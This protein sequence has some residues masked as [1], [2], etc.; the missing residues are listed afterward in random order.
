MAKIIAVVPAR[1]GSK[2]ILRKN[3][4]KLGKEPLINY[5]LHSLLEIKKI[6]RIIVSTEDLEI[7]NHCLKIDENIEVMDRPHK[8]A[9]DKTPLTSVVHHVSQ[10]L[11]RNKEYHDFVLQVAATC[12]FIKTKSLISIVKTL[13]QK[14]SNCVVTLKRIEHEHPYRA[15]ILKKN[16]TFSHFIKNINVEKYISRQDLPEL[17]CTSGSV[18]G[19][20]FQ[21]LKNFTHKDF[22]L[23][24]KP[25][26]IV[27]DDIESINIDRM[28][29]FQFAEFIIKNNLYR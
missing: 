7:K 23:G 5:I 24:K 3:L 9:D 6:D 12:P 8:L 11:N 26:G 17:Y 20:S 1:A 10:E 15:K 18:Y 16:N 13:T 4:K 2:G 19:R 22:C 28:I 25:Y 27:L 14:K 21:L 29:D